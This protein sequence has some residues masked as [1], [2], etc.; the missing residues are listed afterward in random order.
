MQ[1]LKRYKNFFKQETQTF[2]KNLVPFQKRKKS[3]VDHHQ[4]I[5]RTANLD[6]TND[7][8]R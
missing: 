6:C 3:F 7:K 8:E 5:Q 2:L 4:M 1:Q